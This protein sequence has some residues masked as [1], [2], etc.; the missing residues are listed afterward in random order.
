MVYF[1]KF[2]VAGTINTTEYDAG[3]ESSRENPKRLLSI[4]VQVDVYQGNDLQGWWE[5]EKI[6]EIPDY[7]IDCP[8]E[9]TSNKAGKSFNRLNEIEVGHDLP[10][11]ST[12]QIALSCGGTANNIRGAYRYEI[13]K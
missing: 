11:G 7:L 8:E 10:V 5:R 9:G 4:M 3:L 13:V 6:F 1:Q 12:F 2:E